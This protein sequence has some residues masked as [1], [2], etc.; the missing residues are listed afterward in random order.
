MY[1]QFYN[2]DV[3]PFENKPD[4][5]FFYAS[6]QH[7]EALAAIEYT[8]RMRKGFV[9]VTGAIGSGKTTVG[10]T[11]QHRCA[12]RA[13]IIHLLHGHTDG[14]G[15]TAQVLRMLGIDFDE[16]ESHGRLL[17]RLR[18]SLHDHLRRNEPV[19]VVVDE[20]QTLSD[21]AIEHLRL[22][23]NFDTATDKV[24]QVVLIGQ[25]ELRERIRT[26]RH[27]AL[28]QR[29]AMAKQLRP[30]DEADTAGYIQH[31]LRAAAS[32]VHNPGVRFTDDA[33]AEI[34]AVTGGV[35]RL[36]NIV[37]DN[38]LLL[39][40]VREVREIEP[41]MVYRVQQDMVPQLDVMAPEQES[42]RAP[43]SLAG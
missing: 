35:P 41:A 18:E 31:R 34:Y 37:C 12:S 28:R 11:V 33:I 5:R 23:S 7:R 39:G 43:L 22:L 9:L 40:M 36:I 6:E 25:P 20:A 16:R 13:R 3:L 29:I 24:V 38:C 32:D 17:E 10:H 14:T 4:P 15:I 21:E 42:H 19:V 26:D 8:I 27:A 2:L 1:Q 30:L